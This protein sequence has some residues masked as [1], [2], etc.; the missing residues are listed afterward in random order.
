MSAIPGYAE[1][2]CLPNFSFQLG[3]SQCEALVARA[4]ALG[5]SALAINDEI[6]IWDEAG[7]LRLICVGKFVD[8]DANTVWS[9]KSIRANFQKN[10]GVLTGLP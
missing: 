7:T 8:A 2:N 10:T 3:A 4:A 6:R 9:K 1:L 5:Y